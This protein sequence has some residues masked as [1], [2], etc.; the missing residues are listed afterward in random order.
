ML[1]ILST[2]AYVVNLSMKGAPRGRGV[3]NPQTPVN[4][5][6]DAKLLSTYRM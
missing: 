1:T 6:Y 2:Y 4:V 3:K 5:V